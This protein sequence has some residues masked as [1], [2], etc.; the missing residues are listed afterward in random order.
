MES[1]EIK[2][3]AKIFKALASVYSRREDAEVGGTWWEA[4]VMGH[5]RSLDTLYPTMSYIELY[6][7]FLWRL[8][9]VAFLLSLA[10]V[11]LIARMDFISDYELAKIFTSDPKDFIVLAMNN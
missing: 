9:P 10:L 11:V 7:Q 4:R 3:L 6:Q 2:D 5:I 1:I 8:V